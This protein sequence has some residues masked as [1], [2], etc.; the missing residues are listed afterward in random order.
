MGS[1]QGGPG[2]LQC[3]DRAFSGPER[4]DLGTDFKRD[5][6]VPENLGQAGGVKFRNPDFFA[7]GRYPDQAARMKS[8]PTKGLKVPPQRFS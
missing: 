3:A 2:R 4:V 6:N 7:G 1:P 8:R 5:L